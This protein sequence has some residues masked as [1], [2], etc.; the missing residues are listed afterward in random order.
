MSEETSSQSISRLRTNVHSHCGTIYV[1]LLRW[2]PVRVVLKTSRRMVGVFGEK[3]GEWATVGHRVVTRRSDT[4]AHSKCLSVATQPADLRRSSPVR[5]GGPRAVRKGRRRC[6]LSRPREVGAKTRSVNTGVRITSIAELVDMFYRMI[7][8]V[9]R[10]STSDGSPTGGPS[11]ANGGTSPSLPAVARHVDVM[12]SSAAP[13]GPSQREGHV[14]LKVDHGTADRLREALKDKQQQKK[15]GGGGGGGNGGRGAGA[16]DV[17]FVDERH[18]MIRVGADAIPLTLVDLP[19]VIE[20]QR[21][22]D[23]KQFYKVAD[24]AQMLVADSEL[25]HVTLAKPPS[26]HADKKAPQQQQQ[27]QQQ[28]TGTALL[29]PHGITPPMKNVRRRRFRKPLRKTVTDV[30]FEV[31]RLLE[32]DEAAISVKVVPIYDEV[33]SDD[34]GESSKDVGSNGNNAGRMTIRLSSSGAAKPLAER[35][36]QHDGGDI[37]VDDDEDEYG[38]SSVSTP[39][40]ASAPARNGGD[41]EDNEEEG[42]DDEDDENF[43]G[44]LAMD[45]E[46]EDESA[47]VED[48][49]DE[50]E[51]SVG[52]KGANTEDDDNEDDEDEDNDEEDDEDEDEQGDN[53][54][55]EDDDNSSKQEEAIPSFL[56]SALQSPTTPTTPISRPSSSSAT[57]SHAPFQ[58]SGLRVIKIISFFFSFSFNKRVR[59]SLLPSPSTTLSTTTRWTLTT[60]CPNSS[61][62]VHRMSCSSSSTL[63]TPSSARSATSTKRCISSKRSSCASQT[64]SSR[65][66]SRASCKSSRRSAS[67]SRPS[68][69][70]SRSG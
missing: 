28:E 31:E 30:G 53:D 58:P 16:V 66:D 29:W 70:V 60:T 43:F 24:I 17:A 42:E 68:C 54:D 13:I 64:R 45:I 63:A 55:D 6:S 19:N 9:L 15:S 62:P 41:S 35:Q 2:A 65:S 48:I 61:R 1:F 51:S 52:I 39:V 25:A 33:N 67:H 38:S 56:R 49:I 46:G 59:V 5:V 32:A 8:L 26:Q 14:L 18:A 20:T 40:P 44:Q 12:T 69:T 22:F 4:C 21:T 36:D 57:P 37:H 47:V 50:D 23:N 10:T 7:S 11:G 3:C 27:Q 34:D